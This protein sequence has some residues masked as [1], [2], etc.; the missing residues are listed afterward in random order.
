MAF[1]RYENAPLDKTEVLMPAD[2]LDAKVSNVC[3]GELLGNYEKEDRAVYPWANRFVLGFPLA[4]WQCELMWTNEQKVRFIES[5]WT[6]VDLGSYMI[7]RLWEYDAAGSL[8]Y[9]SD[10][11]VDGQQRLQALQDYFNNEFAVNDINGIPRYWRELGRVQIRR[12]SSISFAR[13]EIKTFDEALL[14]KAYNLRSF[15]GTPHTEAER[16]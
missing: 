11:V 9:L 15:G 6:G 13:A 5:A 8:K 12:F 14:R 3:I 2:E 16:A 1:N 10:V 7:N 4:P